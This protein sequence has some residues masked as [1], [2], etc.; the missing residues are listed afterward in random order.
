ML[1][2]PAVM[3]INAVTSTVEDSGRRRLVAITTH[4]PEES[5]WEVLTAAPPDA[6]RSAAQL[7]STWGLCAVDDAYA[8]VLAQQALL[9]LQACFASGLVGARRDLR[10]P[11]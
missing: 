6:G 5:L 8:A 1:R 3:G 2:H 4:G 10:C 11:R 7:Q 9:A